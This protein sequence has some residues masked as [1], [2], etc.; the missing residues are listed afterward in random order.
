MR[1]REPDDQGTSTAE[2]LR[3]GYE[4][5]NDAAADRER[6]TVLFVP[7]DSIVQSRAWKAQVPYLAQHYRVVTIDPRGNGRS[8]G[9]PT[10]RR[11]ATS[12]SSPTPW[13]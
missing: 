8:T 6:P 1:A 13:R 12:T 10:R 11:T 2:G 7:I 4:T 3:I 5:F 9:P